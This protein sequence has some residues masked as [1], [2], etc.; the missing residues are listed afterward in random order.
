MI[1]I[2]TCSFFFQ[3]QYLGGIANQ[4]NYPRTRSFQCITNEFEEKRGKQVKRFSSSRKDGL[5]QSLDSIANKRL[6]NRLALAWKLL[7]YPA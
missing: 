5:V 2:E 1:V 3:R 4:Q 6:T 7:S